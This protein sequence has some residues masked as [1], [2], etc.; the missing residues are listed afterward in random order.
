MGFVKEF[1]EFAVKGNVIDLAIGVVIGGAFGKIVGSLI[2][3]VITPLILKPALDAAHLSNINELTLMGSV[4][5]GNFLATVIN[6]IIVALVLFMVIKAI[7]RLKRK[8]EETP[9]PPA[10]PTL[11]E[12]LLMEIRDALKK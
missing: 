2:D 4:K 12:K 9:A 11:Q 10:E 3:D 5:Y 8:E 7:N 1:K 6:F